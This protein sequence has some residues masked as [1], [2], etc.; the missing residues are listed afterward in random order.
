MCNI[1]LPSDFAHKTLNRASAK[2]EK[3]AFLSG[4]ANTTTIK[5]S[6][7]GKLTKTMIKSFA[8]AVVKE[9]FAKSE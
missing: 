4:F 3:D 8:C 6:L 2:S 5:S 9:S 7:P 1:S